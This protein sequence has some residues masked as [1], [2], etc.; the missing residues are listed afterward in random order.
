ME[1]QRG[2]LARDLPVFVRMDGQLLDKEVQRGPGLEVDIKAGK[3]GGAL[4][5]EGPHNGVT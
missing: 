5:A 1:T 3:E 2:G 4:P